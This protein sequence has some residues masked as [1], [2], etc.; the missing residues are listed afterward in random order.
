MKFKSIRIKSFRTI[1]EEQ[2]ITLTSGMTIVGP[3]NSGKTNLL[4]AVQ[5]FFTGYDNQYS[6]NRVDDL[7]FNVTKTQT[8]L[9]GSF[10]LDNLIDKEI[11]DL[12][13]EILDLL[14]LKKENNESVSLYLYFTNSSKPVYRVYPNTKRPTENTKKAA[15]SRKEKELTTKLLDRY[16]IYYVPSNKSFFELYNDLLIP[17]LRNQTAKAINPHIGALQKVLDETANHLNRELKKA[18]LSDITAKFCL[19][20]DSVNDLIGSFDFRLL[21]PSETTIFRKGMGIQASALTASFSW[22]TKERLKQGKQ[23][24]WLIE[25]PEAFLHPELN[26]TCLNL[27]NSLKED[28]LVIITTHSLGFVPNEIDRIVGTN[29]EEKRTKVK[30][31]K[32]YTEATKSI[33]DSI[34]VRFSDYFNLSEYN[35]FLEGPSD[36]DYLKSVIDVIPLNHNN[37]ETEWGILRSPKTAFY[38]WG[39]VSHLG[40]FL[41]ASWEHISKERACVSVF[42]SDDAGNRVRKQIQQYFGQKNIPFRPN[43]DFISI[44]K[45]FPIEGL[46]PDEWIIELY[47]SNQGWFNDFSIDALGTLESFSIKDRN[48]NTF[49][50]NMISRIRNVENLD[51]ANR[52][53]AVC[54]TLNKALVKQAEII[55]IFY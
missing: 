25:E 50:K 33:R 6:Y 39:G 16:T 38:E 2:E 43:I 19:P 12:H 51:W 37:N 40:G 26:S 10:E 21:D 15:Y 4:Q 28:A 30:K 45:G 34:G 47:N 35:V 55:T 42:D 46:F 31:Y 29:L 44:R 24:I 8:S 48:K 3:N 32:T 18:G 13:Q 20:N 23:V 22:V 41:R 27:L 9:I 54:S 52:W 14:N 53:I 11:I 7:T 1:F 17:F 36:R 49:A 5:M